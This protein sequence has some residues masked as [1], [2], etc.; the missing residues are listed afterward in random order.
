VG[1]PRVERAKLK[2]YSA[3]EAED[4]ERFKTFSLVEAVI[5]AYAHGDVEIQLILHELL[6][7]FGRLLRPAAGP[8]FLDAEGHF[9]ELH[10]GKVVSKPWI[11]GCSIIPYGPEHSVPLRQVSHGLDFAGRYSGVEGTAPAELS[12]V[13]DGMVGAVAELLQALQTWVEH[14]LF[15]KVEA[16][17]EE[18]A[19]RLYAIMIDAGGPM[20]DKRAFDVAI[21]GTRRGWRIPTPRLLDRALASASRAEPLSD[22]SAEA[23]PFVDTTEIATTFIDTTLPREQLLMARAL[24]SHE[25]TVFPFKKAKY[26]ERS[27]PFGLACRLID[28]ERT[29]LIHPVFDSPRLGVVVIYPADDATL[30]EGLEQVLPEI[31]QALSVNL[32]TFHDALQF[33]ESGLPISAPGARPDR[34]VFEVLEEEVTKLRSDR[35]TPVPKPPSRFRR[36]RKRGG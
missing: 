23:S 12:D 3:L 35:A 22:Q 17:G 15:A 14:Q 31:E 21:I 8:R 29:S 10:L 9:F 33:I 32:S 36:R 26:V 27:S 24:D 28:G 1:T 30:R 34:S 13:L 4:G 7:N 20:S 16:F 11:Y 2:L 6:P 18:V 5:A 25:A 19:N